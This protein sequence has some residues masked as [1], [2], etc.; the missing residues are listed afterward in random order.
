MGPG[1]IGVLR[2]LAASR[3]A[4]LVSKSVGENQGFVQKIKKSLGPQC[5]MIHQFSSGEPN[6]ARLSDAIAQVTEFGPDWIV[7]IGGGS[8]IDQGK[9]VWVFYEH[10]DLDTERAERFGG[11]PPL[12]GKSRFVAVPTTAGS[13]SEVSSAAVFQSE[14]GEKKFWVSHQMLPDIAILDPQFLVTCPANVTAWSGLDALAHLIE[15]YVS[16]NSHPFLDRQIEG[17]LHPLFENL[18]TCVDEPENLTAR[19]DMLHTATIAGWVQNQKI[20]GLAHAIC[21]QLG[22]FDIP[23]GY[24]CGILLG[25]SIRAN[26]SNSETAI[27][28]DH[29]AH[30]LGLSGYEDLAKKCDDFV[31]ALG[32]SNKLSDIANVSRDEI[33]QQRQTIAKQDDIC[34]RFNP[35]VVEPDLV[36]SILEVTV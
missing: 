28:Y 14:T 10:P 12:R 23:H 20:P 11:I 34:S 33:L 29:L 30:L 8:V 32:L 7:A 2:A 18:K 22:R 3:V 35:R 21:H 4:V 5:H 9:M 27:R 25:S 31:A 6:L 13:G 26:A 16:T 1:S 15:G 19:G 24:G 17:A 36:E